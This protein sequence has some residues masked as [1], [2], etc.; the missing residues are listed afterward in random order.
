MKTAIR[1][2]A[3]FAVIGVVAQAA[4][5]LAMGDSAELFLTGTLGLRSDDNVLLGESKTDDIIFQITPGFELKYG[6]N[7]LTQGRLYYKE[8][9]DQYADQSK[10]DTELSSVGFTSA[11]NDQ[12]MKLDFATS[13]EQ[14]AQNTV[15]VRAGFLVRRD[16]F[17]IGGNSE[18]SV[19]EKSSVGAGVS[20]EDI[21]YKR[22]GFVDSKVTT[23]PLNYYYKMS[24]KTDMSFGFEYRDTQLQTNADSNDYFYSIGARG[25]FTPK[26]TGSVSIGY[27]ERDFKAGKDEDSL[28]F[29]ANLNYAVSEKTTVQAGLSNDYGVA[30]QGQSQRNLTANLGVQ[31]QLATDWTVGGSLMWRSIAYL[32][33]G[34]RTDDYAEFQLNATYVYN[35]MV[36]F[37]GSYT[38]RNYNSEISGADFD[39][40]VFAIAANI[41][42]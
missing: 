2:L 9:I 16:V 23:V 25:E 28:G 30:G 17:K 20:Y 14:L 7:A 1:S 34:A 10:L 13:Y 5:F 19:T 41:R 6:N 15:D 33:A 27:I 8:T 31:S 38:F 32:G 40:N 39:N 26:L 42:Y 36:N 22:V 18:V 35:S 3:S 12:K 24:P 11:Y 4:P 37:T 29:R 21:N